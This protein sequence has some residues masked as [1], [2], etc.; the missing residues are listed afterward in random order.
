MLYLPQL[1]IAMQNLSGWL[2][3]E[4]VAE[5]VSSFGLQLAM[6]VV[7]FNDKGLSLGC[8]RPIIVLPWRIFALF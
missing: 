8:V 6:L 4:L 5:V 1:V 3:I 2:I 7:I